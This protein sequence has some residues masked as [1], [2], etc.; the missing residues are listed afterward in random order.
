MHSLSHSIY[1]EDRFPSKFML[2]E[3]TLREISNYKGGER[4][5]CAWCGEKWHKTPATCSFAAVFLRGT[6][7]MKRRSF[8]FL[9][10]SLS[11]SVDRKFVDESASFP[12]AAGN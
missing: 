4:A 1:P 8:L 3:E 11:R 5:A 10:F 2:G 9:L 6:A 12:T 7:V